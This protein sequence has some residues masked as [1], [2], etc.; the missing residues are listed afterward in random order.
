MKSK[1]QK[2][3]KIISI[4][5]GIFLVIYLGISAYGAR[6]AMVIPRLP[7][8]YQA[9][10]LGL[11]YE[12]VAFKSRGDNIIL[13]GWYIPGENNDVILIVHGGFQNR[14]DDNVDTP[15]MTRALVKKGYSV[16]LFDMRGRGESEGEGLSLSNIDEDIGGAA[17]YLMSRG[18]STE[19]ICI[20]G[21]STG[22]A[23]AC[24]YSSRN[25]VGALILDGCFIDTTTMVVRQAD[26]IHV[27]GFLVRFFIPGGIFF[28]RVMYGYHRVEPIDIIPEVKYPI[29]FIHEENDAFTTMEE[30]LRLFKASKNP[31]SEVWEASSALHS[32]GFRVHPLEYVEK[33]DSFLKK[34]QLP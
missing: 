15:G 31:V 22:A 4:G 19:N 28:T 14:I 9:S 26:A 1:K 6:Q 32:Q 5:V 33:M 13:R 27:P 23:A 10:S 7:L 25:E 12:D 17:D 24:I 11:A 21:F 20:M 16:L 3:F 29:L 34:L 8:T 30:T 18:F 2:L